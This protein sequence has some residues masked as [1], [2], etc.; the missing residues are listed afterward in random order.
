MKNY[1][2][3][4]DEFNDTFRVR[5]ISVIRT[6]SGSPYLDDNREL[7]EIKIDRYGLETLVDTTRECRELTS[8]IEE[9]K[10]LREAHPSLD[11]LYSKYL[12]MLVL[13]R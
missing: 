2:S 12:M 5:E 7:I 3:K 8:K 11:E 1:T 13:C 10:R 6:D 9:E 4:Y